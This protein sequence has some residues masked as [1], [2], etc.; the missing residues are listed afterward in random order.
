MC[1]LGHHGWLDPTTDQSAEPAAIESD[2]RPR[3]RPA[4]ID[5]DIILDEA[6]DT[7]ALQDEV[8]AELMELVRIGIGPFS[9][10]FEL[11]IEMSPLSDKARIL[12]RLKGKREE[13][14]Q[15]QQGQAQAG[16]QEMKMKEAETIANVQKTQAQTKQIEADTMATAFKTGQQSVP[17]EP[18]RG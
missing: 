10:E 1:R 2:D 17:A 11:L 5:L 3:L 13:Q 15:A 7:A 12:E 16:E 6:P 4:E 9:P 14:Q 18:Y 8:F